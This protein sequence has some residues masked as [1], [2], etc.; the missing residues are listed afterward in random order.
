M[1]LGSIQ[2]GGLASGLPPDMVDQLMKAKEYRLKSLSR[3][4]DFFTSQ[5][6]SYSELESL[7]SSLSSTANTLQ[8]D[9]S[10]SPHTATSS[11]EDVLE[12]SAD[13]SAVAGTHTIAVS[14]L[15]TSNTIMTGSGVT[16]SSDTLS[17]VTTFSFDYNGQNYT[18][19]DFGIAAGD[20]LATIAS[21]IGSYEFTDADG[22]TEDGISAS[23][24]YDGSN[25][26]LV[27]TAI[28]QGAQSRNSDGTTN[29]TRIENLSI[30]MTF[31]GGAV[32]DTTTATTGT[33]TSFT[34][35]AGV[36]SSTDTV[37]AVGAIPLT[38]DYNGVTY[39]HGDEF[40]ISVGDTLDDIATA[41]NSIG[42][43]GLQAQV[44]NDGTN[45]RLVIEGTS[46]ISN[47]DS[48]FTF[49]SAGNFT[50]ANFVGGY[51]TTAEGQDAKL[52]VDGLSNIYSSENTV[53]DVLPGVTMV[54][55]EV[56]SS[57][58]TVTIAN[59]TDTLKETLSSFTESYN[60]VIDYINDHKDDTLTGESVARSI[61][62][63]MRSVLNTSTHKGDASGDVLTPFSILAEVGLRTNQKTGK[64]SFDSDSL[65]D[66]LDLNFNALTD[67]F[68]N[69]QTAVGTG[70]NAGLA[71]RME[72]LIDS[73]TNSTSGAL[74]GKSDGLQARIDRL[75]DSI[76]REQLRLEKVRERLTL[77]FANLEQLVNT[78]NGASGS[79]I[80]TLGKM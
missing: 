18:N 5:K 76:E 64:I 37:S 39:E 50:D 52:T 47:F 66:A 30:D 75:D 12:V 71:Y 65:D 27:L 78:M 79:L 6:A 55:K 73:L 33:S 7:L 44:V 22:N 53:D 68:T 46:S 45:N 11:D 63:Q 31:N 19:A 51:F 8:D 20:D 67:L 23:V 56:T 80:N 32:Y 36:T 17:A 21:R 70:N 62:S 3:D 9:S 24:L 49:T 16:D 34:L 2:F 35:G 61:I 10:F 15:A 25:Y 74:T 38:F 77:K 59:D 42:A 60:A 14:R 48:D 54:V 29:T 43:A 57:D 69:T 72:D 41:I 28:D 58:I 40:T 26:R 4:K 1:A 13:S